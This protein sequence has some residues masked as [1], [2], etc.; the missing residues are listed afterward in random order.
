MRKVIG[1]VVSYRFQHFTSLAGL[2]KNIRG[3]IQN[4]WL[5]CVWIVWKERNKQI[6]QHKEGTIQI[7]C[8]KIKLQLFGGWKW[9]TQLLFS[10][11]ATGGLI[12]FSILLLFLSLCIL[13]RFGLVFLLFAENHFNCM[14]FKFLVP[15][16]HYNFNFVFMG[17]FDLLKNEGQDI[18]TSVIRCLICKTVSGPGQTGCKDMTKNH[19]FVLH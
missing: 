1:N 7:L 2:S 19:I 10:T 3:N 5:C 6:F 8:D 18:T 9:H 16:R 11:I 14:T 12:I 17:A 15:K 13:V 4:F